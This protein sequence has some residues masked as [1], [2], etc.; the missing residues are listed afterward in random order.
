[1]GLIA[2]LEA[3]LTEQSRAK[4]T[5]ACYSFWCRKFYGFCRRPASQWTGPDVR[6]WLLD[7]AAQVYSAVSR[8]QA[9]NAVVFVFRQLD[10]AMVQPRNFTPM[11]C[12]HERRRT[13]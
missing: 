9:L 3:A 13:H 6:A 4:S 10:V 2:K 7:L 8:K 1:M 12:W 11:G 5:A